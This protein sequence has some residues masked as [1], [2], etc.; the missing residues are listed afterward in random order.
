M[1]TSAWCMGARMI[2]VRAEASRIAQLDVLRGV[3]VMLVLFRHN[4][5]PSVV[6]AWDWLPQIVSASGWIGVDLFFVLGGYLVGGLLL[7]ELR[8]NGRIRAG[9]F[10]ARRFLKV[11]PSYYAFLAAYAGYQV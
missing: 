6:H 11:W 10:I 1:L 3:A 5:V 7:R 2:A 8:S 9:R 4:P